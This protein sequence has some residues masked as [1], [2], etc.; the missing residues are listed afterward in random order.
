MITQTINCVLLVTADSNEWHYMWAELAKRAQNREL[1]EPTVAEHF[2]E[3]WQYME[4]QEVSSLWSGKRLFHCFRHR[5]HPV[6]GANYRIKI[7][8]S[9]NLESGELQPA[10]QR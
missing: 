4:T 10:F 8:A 6:K 1:P 7:P 9:R 3:V 5:L 2:G